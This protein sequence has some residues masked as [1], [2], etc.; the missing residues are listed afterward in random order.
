MSSV[1]LGVTRRHGWSCPINIT[2]FWALYTYIHTVFKLQ[3]YHTPTTFIHSLHL[4]ILYLT[5]LFFSFASL[6]N[7]FRRKKISCLIYHVP[8]R[9]R[10]AEPAPPPRPRPRFF[11]LSGVFVVP[12]I[13]RQ[14]GGACGVWGVSL[15]GH[16]GIGG[17]VYLGWRGAW[18]GAC[19]TQRCIIYDRIDYGM[20]RGKNTSFVMRRWEL[21]YDKYLFFVGPPSVPPPP[22]NPPQSA[23]RTTFLTISS[24]NVV[25]VIPVVV[26]SPPETVLDNNELLVLFHVIYLRLLNLW[27][28]RGRQ[29]T[30]HTTYGVPG[31]WYRIYR[32]MC[33][34]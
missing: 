20:R 21:W 22:L 28:F 23:R 1:A 3:T 29:N 14:A 33:V 5:M 26:I 7:I 9:H 2:A 12:G 34:D 19:A 27:F 4:L 25:I 6:K 16:P 11:V 10:T 31:I 18:A 17:T 30:Y 32:G 24:N 15:G 8:V 13:N